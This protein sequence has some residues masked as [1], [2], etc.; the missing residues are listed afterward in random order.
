MP[1]TK[2]TK[3]Q[4]KLKMA[5]YGPSGAGK[6][7]SALAMATVLGMPVALIDTEH[8]S[9]SKYAGIFAFDVLELESFHPKRYI[10]AIQEAEQAGYAALIID[11]L[12]H[13]WAGKDGALELVDRAAKRNG[14]QNNFAAWRDVTPLHT[15]LMDAIVAAHIHIIATMRSKTEYV[16]EQNERGKSVPRR[17]GLAPIQRSESEYEFDIVGEMNQ[18]HDLII[19]KSRCPALD[20]AVV[21]RPGAEIAATIKSW[22][23]DGVPLPPAPTFDPRPARSAI[24][25]LAGATPSDIAAAADLDDQAL[26]RDLYKQVRDRSKNGNGKHAP[27]PEQDELYDEMEAATPAA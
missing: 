8:G 2:A 12:S 22:L 14:A 10:E 17:V 25:A 27:S 23:T 1:F 19:S 15:A 21:N 7:Y 20:S 11:S 3:Q 6:T 13:A 26:L 5:I 24:A 9:A 4:S 18:E 16:I